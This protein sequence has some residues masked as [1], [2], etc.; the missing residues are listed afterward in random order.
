MHSCTAQKVL[1]TVQ[2]KVALTHPTTKACM[3]YIDWLNKLKSDVI[4][5][6]WLRDK[7]HPNTQK[8]IFFKD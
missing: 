4:I 2:I 7:G 8:K 3:K 6:P 1:G 5:Y